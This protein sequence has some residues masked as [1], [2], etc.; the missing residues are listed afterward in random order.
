[1]LHGPFMNIPVAVPRPVTVGF[2][3][4]AIVVDDGN[5]LVAVFQP[6]EFDPLD[7]AIDQMGNPLGDR[8]EGLV[9]AAARDGSRADLR[10]DGAKEFLADDVKRQFAGGEAL[11]AGTPLVDRL[12]AEKDR[13]EM[14]G[15]SSSR[16]A[17]LSLL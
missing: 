12:L 11:D 8:R 1:M 17:T 4:L 16:Q 2:P 7:G 6:G 3:Q 14:D 5:L 10:F 15:A 13:V 9:A